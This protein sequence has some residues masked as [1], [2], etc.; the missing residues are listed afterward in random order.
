MK[1]I[2]MIKRK[3]ENMN[4]ISQVIQKT[5]NKKKNNKNN[6]KPLKKK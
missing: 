4:G 2:Q 6:K 1:K 3:I 5:K